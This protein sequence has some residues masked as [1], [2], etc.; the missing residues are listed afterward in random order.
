MVHSE[1]TTTMYFSAN[2]NE[3][4]EDYFRAIR[5]FLSFPVAVI[6]KS[7]CKKFC[8]HEQ[9][10]LKCQLLTALTE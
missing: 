7:K 5:T 2:G 3:C 1:E 9:R 6:L 4:N 8:E 10:P